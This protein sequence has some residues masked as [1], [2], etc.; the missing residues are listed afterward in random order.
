MIS[1]EMV[2]QAA[3]IAW[4]ANPAHAES[5]EAWDDALNGFRATYRAETRAVLEY[6]AAL[7]WSE[8]DANPLRSATLGP[9]REERLRDYRCAVQIA[10]GV[11]GATAERVESR[12]HAMLAA[13]RPA[14]APTWD[15]TTRLLVA[16]IRKVLDV[17]AREVGHGDAL[18]EALNDLRSLLPPD[19]KGAA[20]GQS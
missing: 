17:L 8:R 1:N 4:Q 6:A 12:A 10:W 14:D 19:E 13:E 3:K 9:T 15:E 16:G 11:H 7:M 5:G 2:E 18:V 20:D